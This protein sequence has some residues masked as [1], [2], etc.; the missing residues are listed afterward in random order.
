MTKTFVTSD[1]HFNHKN[2]LIYCPNR[3]YDSMEDMNAD[4][5]R[6]WND[7]VSVDD[8][9]YFIGDFAMGPKKEH[10]GFLNALNGTIKIIPG[11]HDYYLKKLNK[12]GGLPS[13]VELLSPIYNLTFEG[14]S[15]VLCHFPIDEWE[16]MT[17]H[18]SDGR[19][20]AIHLH[21]HCHGNGQPKL[22]RYD[23]GWDVYGK[24]IELNSFS[25]ENI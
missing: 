4:M 7:T 11:N 6:I 10:V 2:I 22:D 17:G 13:H 15:F 3:G 25:N 21:G 23:I 5:I 9:V 24:P 16:A 12:Q 14:Q 19:T 1:T 8:V 18:A 20:G